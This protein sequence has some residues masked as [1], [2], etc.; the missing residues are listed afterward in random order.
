M[1]SIIVPVFNQHSMTHDCLAAVHAN[2]NDFELVIV[3]NGS[4]PEFIPKG[5][6]TVIRNV[7]NEGFPRAVNQG[8]R[9]AK[10]EVIVLLNNDVVCVQ[11][12]AQR[13]LAHLDSYSIVGPVSNYC[14]GL[15]QVT[16]PVYQ[17]ER[18]LN[19]QANKWAEDHKGESKEVNWIIGFCMAFKKSL[20]EELGPFDESL[21]PCSG[22]ELDFCLRAREAGHKV[23][24][25]KDVYVHHEGSQTFRA[26]EKAGQVNYQE[27][28]NR[29]EA[30]VRERH[31]KFWGRQAI[32]PEAVQGIRLNMGSG[33]FPMKGFIN[34]DQ[35][36]DVHPDLLCDVTKLPYEPGTVAE[37]YAGHIL[38]H[39][40]FNEGMKALR[41]WHSLLKPGGI[42]SV[43]VP[44]YDF[45]VQEYA[46]NPSPEK[47]I[48]F[49][50]VYIYSG[51]Q[52]SPH[53]YAYSAALL[54]KVMMEA[55]FGDLKRMPVDH[56]YFPFPV[57]WQC[58][59]QGR[60]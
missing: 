24:I 50:D 10:G 51:N 27:I 53:Q 36:E 4:D 15:Q 41:Y 6:A 21:W 1:I 2:T 18:E 54:E 22:E 26:M 49:N 47:L 42:I 28:C 5:P 55:G 58:G 8:I 30:N 34:I 32:I 56:H 43:V 11:G 13:L 31:G 17:D 38:E 25:T 7:K 45:L 44:D 39:L 19:L 9:A 23:G 48:I 16:I 40:R 14:A 59:F 33:P 46:E 52:P 20:W 57:E 35:F 37:I 60:R 3:D 12:W 29:N